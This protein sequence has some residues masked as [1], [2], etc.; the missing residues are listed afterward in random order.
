VQAINNGNYVT[1]RYLTLP[2]SHEHRCDV[3]PAMYTNDIFV[4]SV[5]IRN[6]HKI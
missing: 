1:L 6:D 3:L 2:L 4:L 5:T